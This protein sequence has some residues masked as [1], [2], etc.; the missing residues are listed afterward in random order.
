MAKDARL[1]DDDRIHG[2]VGSVCERVLAVRREKVD[3]VLLLKDGVKGVY[4]SYVGLVFVPAEYPSRLTSLA[5]YMLA[6]RIPMLVVQ[7]MGRIR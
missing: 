1:R 4:R 6:F 3:W 5:W 7:N 2:T